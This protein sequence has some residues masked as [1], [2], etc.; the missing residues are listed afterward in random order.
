MEIIQRSEVTPSLKK[1]CAVTEHCTGLI[2]GGRDRDRE[3]SESASAEVFSIPGPFFTY[4]NYS[5]DQQG[6]PAHPV[7]IQAKTRYHLRGREEGQ[8]DMEGERGKDWVD[9]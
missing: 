1:A 8:R 3:Q 7:W 2:E 5:N 6:D 4:V 9:K